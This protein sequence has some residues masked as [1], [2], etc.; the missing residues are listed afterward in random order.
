MTTKV[1]FSTPAGH[2][3]TR[4]WLRIAT[5]LSL[6]V[7]AANHAVAQQYP[8]GGMGGGGSTNGGIYTAP[9]G[10]YGSAG[11]AAA[12][13]VGAAAGAGALYLALR[14]HA[15]TGCVEPG[16]DGLRFVDEKKNVSYA[17]VKSDV[18]LKAGQRVE[19]EGQRSKG[20]GPQTF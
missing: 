3:F 8:Q 5:G 10:G 11:K 15:V 7:L 14:H 4:Q 17:L 2:R 16:E 13:G 9:S 1:A 18:Y 19:L 12:I 6:A 20:S